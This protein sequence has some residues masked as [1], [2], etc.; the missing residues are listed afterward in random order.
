MKHSLTPGADSLSAETTF[1][2]KTRASIGSL[3]THKAE[4]S[5]CINLEPVV[6]EPTIR[7]KQLSSWS[8]PK[9]KSPFLTMRLSEDPPAKVDDCT[10]QIPH[11]FIWNSALLRGGGGDNERSAR[12][13]HNEICGINPSALSS[14]P[15]GNNIPCPL[16]ISSDYVLLQFSFLCGQV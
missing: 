6:E 12:G 3:T 9:F 15:S 8:V 13:A 10:L 7:S 14:C 16:L 1:K 11:I 5:I 2:D 4:S